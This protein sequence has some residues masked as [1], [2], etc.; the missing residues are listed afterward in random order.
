MQ[1]DPLALTFDLDDTLWPIWP[2]IER[3]ERVLWRW[4]AEHAPA[5]AAEYDAAG[6]RKLRVQVADSHP[7]WA[8]D[9]SALRRESLRLAL[10]CAGDDP[11]MASAA[12]DVFF[13]ERQRVELYDDALPALRRLAA[14][15][16]LLALSNGNANLARIGL[17]E[18]F[19]GCVTAKDFGIGKP[20]PRIFHEACR[21]LD[22][23]A[24][25][26]LHVGDDLDLDVRG[27]LAA[28]LQAAWVH[29]AAEAA[30][31][32]PPEGASRWPDLGSLAD[33]LNC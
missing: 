7:E 10:A 19:V 14:R 9:L 12:F 32:E 22:R 31:S 16:P 15:Y 21:L 33:H 24:A 23:P 30:V 13:T 4:L 6:L 26:V 20:D 29:R 28:G 25:R 17:S 8:H 2:T 1:H 27:A 3:A 5:T 11:A 18:Y